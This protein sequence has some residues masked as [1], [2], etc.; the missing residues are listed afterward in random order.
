MLIHFTIFIVT[1]WYLF[2]QCM[3]LECF[4][5]EKSYNVKTHRHGLEFSLLL[6]HWTKNTSNLSNITN[7]NEISLN[8]KS[9]VSFYFCRTRLRQTNSND[10]LLYSSLYFIRR[11]I[12]LIYYILLKYTERALTVSKLGDSSNRKTQQK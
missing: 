10:T 7:H 6:S 2:I 12:F 3:G 5:D 4:L 8:K 1:I 9:L 11:S